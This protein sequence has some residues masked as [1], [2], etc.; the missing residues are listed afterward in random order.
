[1]EYLYEL[2]K[3]QFQ[4]LN[5]E[6]L[7][8]FL[9]GVKIEHLKKNCVLIETGEVQTDLPILISGVLRGYLLGVDGQDITDSFIFRPGDV[10]M[11]CHGIGEISPVTIESVVDCQIARIPVERILYYLEKRPAMF[12]AYNRYI[13]QVLLRY[14]EGKMLLHRCSA[15]ERYRWFLDNYPGLIDVVSNKHVASFLG[16]TPVTLSR[17]RR[18]IRESM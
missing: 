13:M 12:K 9:E 5:Q 16:M 17:L 14:W 15:M 10:A 1:M 6:E 7:A 18:K 4:L 3:D 2:V 11:N 8:C